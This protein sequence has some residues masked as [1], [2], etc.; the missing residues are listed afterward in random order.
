MRADIREPQRHRML[1]QFP[2]HSPAARERADP[3][4]CVLI[5]PD[6]DEPLKLIPRLI[7]HPERHIPGTRH[8]PRSFNH[9]FEDRIE[10]EVGNYP[11]GDLKEPPQI[12]AST[13]FSHRLNASVVVVTRA[14]V[15]LGS[16]LDDTIAKP[17][18]VIVRLQN[19]RVMDR[20]PP[21]HQ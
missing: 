18:D 7:Q 11:L 17:P 13:E 10:I 12:Q 16:I 9:P 1:N 2:Q 3:P 15:T 6:G 5:D 4:A 14:V 8:L 21:T 19:P 20:R